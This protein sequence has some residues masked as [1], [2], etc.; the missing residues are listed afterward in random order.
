MSTET[1]EM[2]EMG[3]KPIA[4]HAW[5][6]Q[7]VGEWKVETEMYMGPGQPP[8]SS[9]GTESCKSVGGLWAF[10]EGK[11]K[12]P[13]GSGFDMYWTLGY[14]VS[15]K[16]YRG[17]WF[18]SMSSHLWKYVGTLS[19]DGKTMTLDCEGPDMVHDGK[20]APYRDVLEIV[21]ANH[22]TLTSYGKDE[23][24]EWQRFMKASFTRV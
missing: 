5:L 22:R 16:E 18:G 4:E 19:A 17:C 7:L 12:M 14:D 3:T 13:D 1:Q 21:D 9:A 20:T 10:A 8:M 2:P 15:F 11:G 6:Q 24:G 23:N